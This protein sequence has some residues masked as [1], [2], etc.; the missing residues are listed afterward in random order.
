MNGTIDTIE[1][2]KQ[3]AADGQL[4]KEALAG[5]LDIES[6][7]PYLEACAAIEKRYT[8]ERGKNDPRCLESGCSIDQAA[9][10]AC[11]QPL[12]NALEYRKACAAEWIK[13]FGK[14][15]TGS[16]AWKN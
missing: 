9:G 7:Q 16:H 4:S 1:W 2:L 12:L 11:L 6:R 14:P 13:L 5:L 10:E 3:C 15:Q 8:E